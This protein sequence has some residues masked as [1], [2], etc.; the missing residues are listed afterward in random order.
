[1]KLATLLALSAIGAAVVVALVPVDSASA[2]SYPGA[3]QV[4]AAKA[5][6]RNQAATVADL[7]KAVEQLEQAVQEA[8]EALY[9]AQEL[10]SEKQELNIEAQRQLFA[11]NARAD[12]AERALDDAR[13][14]LAV[15]AMASYREGGTMGSFEAILTADGFEDVITRSEALN[16]ASDDATVVVDRVRAAELVAQTMRRH[17]QEAAERA[18]QAEADAED[19]YHGAIRANIDAELAYEEA[20]TTR[21]EAVEKLAQLRRTSAALEAQRQ[22]GL[23]RARAAAAQRAAAERAR[24]AAI[25]AQAAAG[26]DWGDL[27]GTDVTPI[28]GKSVGTADQGKAAVMFALA[29]L[30]DPYVWGGSGPNSWD[31]SGLTSGSWASVGIYIPHNSRQQ[32]AYVGKI[33]YTALRPGDL[34]FWGYNGDGAQVYHVAMYIENNVIVEAPK[35]GDVVK[36]RDYRNWNVA[37]LTPFAGRP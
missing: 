26:Y 37:N 31:C 17:A 6:V 22:A 36:T 23:A 21:Q 10:Y 32:Y 7:D 18:I 16:R 28:Y 11:A 15:V 14:D 20:E 1:M 8:E 19:A 13:A 5:A 12:E 3:A 29:Q 4:R 33:P 27:T 24:L 30:G 34:I 2:D 25:A 35:P 9:A